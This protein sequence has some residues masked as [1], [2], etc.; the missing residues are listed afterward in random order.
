[1]SPSHGRAKSVTVKALRPDHIRLSLPDVVYNPKILNL[2]LG[3]SLYVSITQRLLL[4]GLT[5]AR[6]RAQ[7]N[8]V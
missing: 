7:E 8:L 5:S 2:K 1:M 4:A 6:D 3:Y